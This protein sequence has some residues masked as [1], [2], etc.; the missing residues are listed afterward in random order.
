MIMC[1]TQIICCIIV[2][3]IAL[4]YFVSAKEKTRSHKWYSALL[5]TSFLQLIMDVLS[6][7]TVHNMDTVAPWI[8][9]LVHQGFMAFM[10][11]I[12]F[13]VYK[14]IETVIEEEIGERYKKMR[15]VYIPLVISFFG[16]IFLPIYFKE[17]PQGNYSYGPGPINIYISIAIYVLLIIVMLFRYGRLLPRRKNGAILIVMLSE[18]LIAAYQAFV[19][20]ALISCL[21][22]TLLNLCF[23][24]MVENPDAILVD[25]LKKETQRADI[26]NRAKTDFLANMS[27]EIRTPINSMVGMTEMI[28]REDDQNKI[29][30]YAADVQG[31]TKSLLSIIND[32]LD[33]T[34]IEAG[35]MAIVPVEY[36]LSNM[37]DEVTGMMD[38]KAKEKSLDFY[39]EVDQNIPDKLYGDDIHIKQVLVNL[40]GNA[41][42]YTSEGCVSMQVGLKPESDEKQAQIYFAVKDT[43]QGIKQEDIDRIMIPYER[44]DINKNRNVE[45]SGLGLP[46]TFRLLAEMGSK[47]KVESEYGKGSEFSF[48][49]QQGI[50]E[51][52]TIAEVKKNKDEQPEQN[53][54][55]TPL[56]EAPDAKVL[57]VDDNKM[58]RKVFR[59]LLSKTKIQVDEAASG[60]ECLLMVRENY[61]DI[62]FMDH[63]MPEMDGIETYHKMKEMEEY[64]CKKTPVVVVTANA[65]IGAKDRYIIKEGFRAYLSKPID[66]HKLEKVIKTLLKKKLLHTVEPENIAEPQEPAE[67]LPIVNGLDWGYA[68]KHFNSRED[69]LQ[70]LAF[71]RDSLEAEA[72]ELQKLYKKMDEENGF[73]QYCT[74]IHSMKNSAATVGIIP[75]AGM[76][77][78]M[79]DAARNNQRGPIDAMMPIFIEKWL[80]Y[81]EILQEFAGSD[82]ENLTPLEEFGWKEFVDK[83][84]QAAENMDISALDE[85]AAEL[86]NYKVPETYA[87]QCEEIQ[88]AIVRFDVEYLMTI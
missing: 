79:E 21:G 46:I 34:K 61:Y 54:T 25:L 35:K 24:L 55:Y 13:V 81:K 5:I 60:A 57:V 64:P 56:F 74:K 51:N 82:E 10:L 69:L 70:T 23:Y 28:L 88:A 48:V 68:E 53:Y 36:S 67:E 38:F 83:I 80:A 11:A 84:R 59:A 14:Y 49:L 62:I 26:A 86:K 47:M 1:K 19:P 15:W 16:V 66:Y 8:N 32:I 58:N 30:E 72:L 20:T 31:A 44:F 41:F 39:V 75:L 18:A 12:F 77:K 6:V 17:T 33:I 45:G 4:F 37:L 42:K 50:V 43:G 76:A 22:I 73:K 29:K 63:M 85:L 9:R 40:L 3:F 7:I 71:F 78:V 27:H 52:T 87:K 65:V 2:F